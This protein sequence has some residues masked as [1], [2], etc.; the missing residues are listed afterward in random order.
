MPGVEGP[1]L[2]GRTLTLGSWDP[3]PIPNRA[4]QQLCSGPRTGRTSFRLQGR[5]PPSCRDRQGPTASAAPTPQ[6][7]APSSGQVC[8]PAPQWPLATASAVAA[9]HP[10]PTL[11]PQGS[12]CE[13]FTR[14]IF[15]TTSNTVRDGVAALPVDGAAE[16]SHK[17][18]GCGPSLSHC[19]SNSPRPVA[20]LQPALGP[21]VHPPTGTPVEPGCRC[22]QVCC[23]PAAGWGPR[24]PP[25]L[26]HQGTAGQPRLL[27]AHPGSWRRSRL[28]SWLTEPRPFPQ[29]AQAPP[30]LPGLSSPIAFGLERLSNMENHRVA[31]EAASLA[32][33]Q[34][35]YFSSPGDQS[36]CVNTRPQSE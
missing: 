31:L 34:L 12:E 2:H 22:P 21:W 4:T 8:L 19:P 3:G 18:P 25:R 15:H 35:N 7:A 10:A 13:C 36:H 9:S 24:G 32:R 26:Q 23:S 29:K 30:E 27:Q 20:S 28:G 5:R 16:G 33:P 1:G 14:K 6:T 11:G 17:L